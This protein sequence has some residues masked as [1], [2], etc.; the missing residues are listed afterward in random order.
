[1]CT[2]CQPHKKKVGEGEKPGYGPFEVNFSFFCVY[3]DF[4][5]SYVL[6]L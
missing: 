6:G 2:N 5:K 1:M 4:V 3:N